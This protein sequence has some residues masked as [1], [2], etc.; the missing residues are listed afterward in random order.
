MTFAQ[1]IRDELIG[2]YTRSMASQKAELAALMMLDSKDLAILENGKILYTDSRE[3]D[4]ELE[5]RK[6]TFAVELKATED[7]SAITKSAEAKRAFLRGTY[8][9]TG[10]ASDPEKE[11]HFEVALPDEGGAAFVM[12]LLESFG[13]EAKSFK[14][15]DR[16][17]VYVKDAES[18]ADVLNIIEAHRS[19]LDFEN[20]RI[21]REIKGAV[22]R[23]LNCD[24][25]NINKTVTAAMKQLG[26]IELLDSVTGIE[27]L[28][29]GLADICRARLENPDASLEEIGSLLSPPVGKSGANHRFRKLAEMAEKIRNKEKSN[30]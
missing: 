7:L 16:Q 2:H 11:Y 24:T 18:I 30:G 1:E 28:E 29:E 12:G 6:K 13:V 8:I 23:K 25:A 26:D 5:H 14:R 15:R 19:L 17:V 21:E 3:A 9:A 27:N 10:I 4:A 20:I 22:N